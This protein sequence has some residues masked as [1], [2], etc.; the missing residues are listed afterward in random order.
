MVALI[1]SVE[2]ILVKFG[3]CKPK[4]TI[5]FFFDHLFITSYR[6][7]IADGRSGVET[8]VCGDI[9]GFFL[10]IIVN[11]RAKSFLAAGLTR[12]P[13]LSYLSRASERIRL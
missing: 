6:R 1:S 5:F 11:S 10:F 7:K 12:S 8:F 3:L 9:V 13:P 2:V 4:P